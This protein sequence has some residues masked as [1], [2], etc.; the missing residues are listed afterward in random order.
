MSLYLVTSSSVSGNLSRF[1]AQVAVRRGIRWLNQHA[2]RGWYRNLFHPMPDGTTY[3]RA[4]FLSDIESP[5]TLA[6]EYRPEFMGPIGYVTAYRILK[7]FGLST[8][9]MYTL[10]FQPRLSEHSVAISRD[11]LSEVWEEKIRNFD[12]NRTQ[13][14]HLK[15]GEVD[16]SQ[17][18]LSHT[19]KLATLWERLGVMLK[20]MQA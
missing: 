17:K 13:F 12:F 5:L 4:I 18:L 8:T 1:R 15:R 19:E 16:R 2:P 20:R 6:F 11:L 10:G 7:Y 9:K 3:F 14:R